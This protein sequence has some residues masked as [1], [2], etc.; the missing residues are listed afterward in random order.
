MFAPLLTIRRLVR[1]GA[2]F[3]YVCD[4][5]FDRDGSRRHV[6]LGIQQ[7]IEL[8]GGTERWITSNHA[9]RF[10]TKPHGEGAS[11][12]KDPSVFESG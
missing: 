2:G 7:L 11:S 3:I 9:S 4:L 5:A 12:H 10:T 1:L 6:A 8:E